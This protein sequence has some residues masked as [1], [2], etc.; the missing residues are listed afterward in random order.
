TSRIPESPP[1]VGRGYTPDETP[2]C[3][4]P[5]GLPNAATSVMQPIMRGVD[6]RPVGGVTPTYGLGMP[7]M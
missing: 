3:A 1:S 6:R 7:V 2:R 4:T 5:P